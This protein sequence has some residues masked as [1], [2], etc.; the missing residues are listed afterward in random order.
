MHAGFHSHAWR[1]HLP[2]PG[3][4]LWM[5]HAS[6]RPRT[7]PAALTATRKSQLLLVFLDP[8]LGRAWTPYHAL[9]SPCGR[10]INRYCQLERAGWSCALCGQYNEHLN[11][12]EAKCAAIGLCILLI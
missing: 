5:H 10:Y 7:S 9:I 8:R 3:L 1:S 4:R 6:S 12:Q 2:D 11:A